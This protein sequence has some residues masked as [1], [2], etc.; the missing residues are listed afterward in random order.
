[1]QIVDAQIH[2]GPGGI[3]ERLAAMDALGIASVL[4]D[5]LWHGAAHRYSP[6]HP[7]PGGGYRP[8]A[9][10]AELAAQQWPERFSYVLRVQRDD[11]EFAQVIRQARHAPNLRALRLNPGSLPE[12]RAAFSEGG[13]DAICAAACDNGL[14]IFIFAPDEPDALARCARAFP[15]LRL[16]VDHCGVYSNAM[17]GSALGGGSAALDE[18]Q[19]MAMF[20]RVLELARFPNV[21]FK[22]SHFS[23][24]FDLPAWP[25]EALRPIL[26]KTLDAFGRERVMWAS[27]FSVNQ[28]GEAWAELLYSVRANADLSAEEIEWLLGR[29]VRGWLGWT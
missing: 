5:E 25:G 1:M 7:L 27:D 13:Y 10:T 19:H 22:W 26:R 9:P 21:A 14:P 24:M 23:G 15:D 16:I 8:I 3:A 2:M 17:R 11:P 28:R 29:A 20:E 4:V 18:G 12:N 6:C